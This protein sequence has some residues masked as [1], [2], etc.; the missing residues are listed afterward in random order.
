M[1]TIRN[2]RRFTQV[3]PASG[4]QS[5]PLRG[6]IRRSDPNGKLRIRRRWREWPRRRGG[7][8]S[9][10]GQGR[11]GGGWGGWQVGTAPTPGPARLC[12]SMG[13]LRGPRKNLQTCGRSECR[14]HI[15][16]ETEKRNQRCKERSATRKTA[17]ARGIQSRSGVSTHLRR[18]WRDLA[19]LGT[20][21]VMSKT[22]RTE[23]K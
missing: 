14:S 2:R 21:V 5:G 4:R 1:R 7:Q 15:C 8:R 9:S 23:H 20:M 18:T 16:L 17:E 11:P 6:R 19:A 12:L 3:A 22:A 10:S 13:G